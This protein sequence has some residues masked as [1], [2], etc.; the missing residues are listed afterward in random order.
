MRIPL[1]FICPIFLTPVKT[2]LL[3][4]FVSSLRLP[5][6]HSYVSQPCLVRKSYSVHPKQSMLPLSENLVLIPTPASTPDPGMS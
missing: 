4:I 6:L 3:P 1:S 5:K 2:F